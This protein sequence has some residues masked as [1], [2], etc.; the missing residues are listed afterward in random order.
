MDADQRAPMDPNATRKEREQKDRE[1][2]RKVLDLFCG[3]FDVVDKRTIYLVISAVST[4]SGHPMSR[5]AARKA[6]E[7]L[8]A[9]DEVVFGMMN[10]PR[11]HER[12][13]RIVKK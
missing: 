10:R 9:S 12:I 13:A 5:R 11:T 2:S 1:V 6:L 7:S 8:Y 4:A 3:G